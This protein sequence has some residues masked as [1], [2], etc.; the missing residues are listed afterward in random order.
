[1]DDALLSLVLDRID[2]DQTLDDQTRLLVFAACQGELDMA[3]RDEVDPVSRPDVAEDAPSAEPAGAYLASI[4]VEGFRGVGPVQTLEL[5]PG[6]GFTLVVGRNGSGKSSF[7]EALELLL[8]GDSLRWQGRAAAWKE[9][10]RNLHHEHTRVEAGLTV[11]GSR[12]TTTVRRHWQPGDGLDA[13]AT[14]VQPVGR[15]KTDLAA[16]GWGEA[17]TTY[18]PFLSYNELGSLLEEVPSKLFDALESI[19]GLD[20]LNAA[21]ELLR[22]A[23]LEREREHRAAG[24]ALG[25]LLPDLAASDDARARDCHEALSGTAWDLDRVEAAL[26]D[27]PGETADALD[28]LRGL[29]TLQGPDL[30][31]VET[32]VG[33][34]REAVEAWEAVAG[35]DA[36]NADRLADLLAQALAHHEHHGDGDCPVCGRA[37]ALDEDWQAATASE[38]EQLRELSHGV[39]QARDRLARAQRDARGHVAAPPTVFGEAASLDIDLGDAPAWWQRW[40]EGAE[41]AGDARALADHLESQVLGL[42]EAV[43]NARTAATHELERRQAT[44]QP[45]ANRLASWHARARAARDGH[46]QVPALRS[47][48]DWLKQ[49]TA[50]LRKERFAPIAQQ[51]RAYWE[52]LRQD[53]NV[54]LGGVKLDGSGTRR[55]VALDVAVDGVDG[56]A[57]GVMSQGELHALALSLFLPRATLPESPFRFLVIDDPVQSMDPARVDGLAQVLHKVAEQRQIVVFTH[58][59]RLAESVRRLRLPAR[60]LE[61]TRRA[62]SVVEVR[63][64]DDPV[65]R[66]LSDARALASTTDLPI[67]VGRRVVPGFCRAAMEAACAEAFRRRR[68]TKG[69]PHLAVEEALGD[70]RTLKQAAA[71]ALFD[72]AGRAGEVLGRLGLFGSADAFKACD[73]GAHHGHAGDDLHALI[74]DA[75]TIVNGLRRQ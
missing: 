12:G 32:A 31:Q 74:D 65:D 20:E 26:A 30:E 25:E 41:Q 54:E 36:A 62:Q 14:V 22:Q 29:S 27:R 21:A 3:L 42:D 9:G 19:L 50:A 8:T 71:L 57:I 55:R 15:P 5:T 61:V 69:E 47:G 48:E 51:C 35:S 70:A 45:L 1:M 49:T 40:S 60:V 66:L 37:G 72:D 43:T 53:S 39:R 33:E 56:A 10:W 75:E 73:K 16:L 34:L 23:R 44:W 64:G 24:E 58:D 46:A 28:A 18:R 63:K 38:V 17:L 59:D 67:E 11:E 2:G 68:L 6:P 7:A 52:Q 13:S 4:T